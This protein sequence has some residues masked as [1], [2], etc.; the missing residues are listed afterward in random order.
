[1]IEDS[2]P[3]LKVINE[4]I[5]SLALRKEIDDSIKVSILLKVRLYLKALSGDIESA[6]KY[7][8]EDS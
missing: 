8:N 3:D 2:Y 4:V 7:L 5:E 6:V 1:V